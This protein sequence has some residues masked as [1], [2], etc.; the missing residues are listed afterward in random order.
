MS[1]KTEFTD[2]LAA[3][4]AGMG[5][6]QPADG[7]SVPYL[8]KPSGYEVHSLESLLPAPLG[9]RAKVMLGTEDSFIS[10][11]KGHRTKTTAI[12]AAVSS[13]GITLEAILDYHGQGEDGA[14][15]G[16]HRA[17]YQAA[18]TVEWLRWMAKDKEPM[19][20]TAFAEFLETNQLSI[21]EPVG[22]EIL[23]MVQ[24]LEGVKGARFQNSQRLSNGK[25]V[26][27]YEEEVVLSGATGT[28]K[29]KV[30]FPQSLT[31][32]IAPFKGGPG[33]HFPA[34]LRYRIGDKG[35]ITFAIET[36]DSHR[37]IEEAAKKILAKVQEALGIEVYHGSATI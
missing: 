26:L 22:A 28:N 30:E 17:T 15:W 14:Q 24:T 16:R 37:V 13:C 18:T 5:V 23:E 21:T 4:V 3:A 8:I 7:D 34:R 35:A 6:Q 12:F 36:V 2:A 9:K 11:V 1:D 29:G 31:V 32:S 27:N 25:T 10:Y 20:Q 33:Y 19:N